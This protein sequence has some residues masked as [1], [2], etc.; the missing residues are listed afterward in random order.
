MHPPPVDPWGSPIDPVS[1]S[2]S[3]SRGS[4]PVPPAA[5]P[6]PFRE[7]TRE[8]P[9]LPEPT[10]RAPRIETPRALSWERV[11][12]TQR[13]R[14]SDGWGFTAAGLLVAFCGWGLW[15][16]AGRGSGQSSLPGLFVMLT[17]ATIVFVISRYLGFVVLEKMLGRD[18]PHARWTH[19]ATGMFLAVAGVAY[20]MSSRWLVDGGDWIRDGL[21]WLSTHADR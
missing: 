10:R 12:N 8:L 18:R 17:V 1:P 6:R 16:A 14:L 15:A 21:N 19:F 4:V 13:R 20:F 11:K 3:Y 2:P 7:P 5:P 9:T